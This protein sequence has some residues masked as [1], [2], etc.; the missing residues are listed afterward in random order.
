MHSI[1][2]GHQVHAGSLKCSLYLLRVS[3]AKWLDTCSVQL[4]M[5]HRTGGCPEDLHIGNKVGLQGITSPVWGKGKET[6]TDEDV[7][8]W[9]GMP[10]SA[11]NGALSAK[12]KGT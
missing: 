9:K 1:L 8:S 6:L 2:Q 3:R 12:C 7:F 5:S 4:T 10:I 11:A